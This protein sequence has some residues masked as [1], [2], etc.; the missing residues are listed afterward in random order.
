MRHFT[1]AAERVLPRAASFRAPAGAIGALRL[2]NQKKIGRRWN[3]G[4][5][6]RP[7]GRPQR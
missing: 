7:R 4:G 1:T 6:E 3:F 2:C 5:R